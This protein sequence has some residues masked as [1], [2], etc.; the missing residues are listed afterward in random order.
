MALKKVYVERQPKVGDW[1]EATEKPF[2]VGDWQIGHEYQVIRLFDAFIVVI[3]DRMPYDKDKITIADGRYRVFEYQ[4][5][6]EPKETHVKHYKF[7][8]ISFGK[9]TT[10]IY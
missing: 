3:G 10:Y 1:V 4:E 7:L 8:G 2:N 9:R 5:V 6:P